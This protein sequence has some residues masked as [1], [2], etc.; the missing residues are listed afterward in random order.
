MRPWFPLALLML[1]ACAPP[2]PDMVG[3]AESALVGR[4]GV[5][6]RSQAEGDRRFLTYDGAGP[7]VRP[8]LGFGRFAG[9][10]G[11]GMVVGA[12]FGLGAL[13]CVTTYELRGG[14]V[15]GA[16]RQGPGCG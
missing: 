1:G 15:V 11:G 6:A 9:G 7:A 3:L 5:P 8:L 2:R 13:P 4:L 16:V 12:G 14:V 10:W